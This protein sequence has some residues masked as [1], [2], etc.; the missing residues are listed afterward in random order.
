MT[1]SGIDSAAFQKLADLVKQDTSRDKTP[2]EFFEHN[3]A[4]K[5]DNSVLDNV[6]IQTTYK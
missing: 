1:I 3:M 5:N 4:G 2:D 6:T